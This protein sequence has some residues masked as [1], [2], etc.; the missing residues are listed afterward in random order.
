[1]NP[2]VL[3][4]AAMTALLCFTTVFAQDGADFSGTWIK[5]APA[6]DSPA[7]PAAAEASPVRLVIEQSPAAVHVTRQ[8]L[9]GQTDRATYSFKPAQSPLQKPT[10]VEPGDRKDGA[11]APGPAGNGIAEAQAEW[12]DGGLLLLTTLIVNGKPVTTTERLT[13]SPET[14]KLVVETALMVHHGYES[15]GGAAATPAGSTSRDVYT[16]AS[17]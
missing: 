10:T 14:R 7:L 15:V 6:I 3:M 4:T 17:E 16:R 2:R 13:M 12:K 9:N 11:I 1:M 5:D 8:R